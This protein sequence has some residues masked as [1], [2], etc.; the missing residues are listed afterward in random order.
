MEINI[1][2]NKPGAIDDA[3][4]QI[5]AYRYGLQDKINKLIEA[6]ANDGLTVAKSWLMAAQGDS[7][8]ASV[9]LD[10]DNEG[11]ILSAIINLSG[12]DAIFVEFGA[13]YYYN[14]SDPPH[15]AEFGYG[16]GT[17]PNQKYAFQ[18]GWY[19][20]DESGDLVYSHGTEGTYPLYHAA[21]NIRNELIIKALEVFRS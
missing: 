17:Y 12:E 18:R 9:G 3:I 16:V 21:E 13:G 20:Y 4:K 1:N 2:L 7:S 19:H 6:L 14:A 5:K 10:F 11:N 15:A 8:R